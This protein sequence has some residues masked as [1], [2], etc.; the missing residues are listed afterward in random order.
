M[1]STHDSRSL[2]LEGP[3]GRLEAILWTPKDTPHPPLAA[4]VCHPHPL[5]AGTMHNKVVY[6]A[7]KSMDALGMPVLR[8]NFRGAGLSAGVH[9]HGRGEQDD[10]RAA[11][12]F[13]T[14][15]FPGVPLL[16]AGFSFGALVGLR[17]GCEHPRVSQ[18]IGLGIPVDNNDFSFLRQCNKPK[19]FVQ[20]SNDEYGAVATV[21]GLVASLP[22]ENQ[23]VIVEGVDHFFAGKLHQLD[24]AIHNWFSDTVFRLRH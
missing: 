22:G 24:A 18:L 9:D 23:L 21:K 10:V 19:L 6:Q 11:L 3:A 5:F 13:L 14:A 12:D 20:G 8:F 15:E 1:T 16:L 2:F 4:T 7:A 17:A